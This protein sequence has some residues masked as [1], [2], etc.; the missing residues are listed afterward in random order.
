[1]KNMSFN[2]ALVRYVLRK[3]KFGAFLASTGNLYL[4]TYTSRKSTSTKLNK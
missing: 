4:H 2:Y 1:M 3:N